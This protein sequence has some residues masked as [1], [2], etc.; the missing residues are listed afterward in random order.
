MKTKNKFRIIKSVFISVQVW[1]C[2]GIVLLWAEAV[3][4]PIYSHNDDEIELWLDVCDGGG[5]YNLVTNGGTAKQLSFSLYEP[6]GCQSLSYN[7]TEKG[8]SAGFFG[9]A[10][11]ASVLDVTISEDSYDFGVLETNATTTSTSALSVSNGPTCD[12]EQHYAMKAS[13]ATNSTD[14]VTWT[15]AGTQDLDQY[16]LQAAFHPSASRP[17]DTNAVWQEGDYTNTLTTTD[18]SC[19]GGSYFSIDGT[20]TGL[21][22]SIGDTKHLWLRIKTPTGNSSKTDAASQSN[23]M[24]MDLTITAEGTGE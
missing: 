8:L 19:A 24:S 15:L 9:P 18:T 21:Y 4:T 6:G 3:N 14:S 13:N 10:L 2:F 17:A 23:T 5:G 1:L 7:D 11:S 16:V 20:E 22:V 12:G